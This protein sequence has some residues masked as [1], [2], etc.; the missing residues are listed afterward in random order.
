[1][2]T[3]VLMD[4]DEAKESGATALFGEKYDATVRV[5][6]VNDFS[7]ELC[8]GT[9][10]RATGEIGLCKIVSETGIAA[11]VR[12]VEAITG[13]LAL[14]KFQQAEAE[15]DGLA[16][17]L[18]TSSQELPA[19]VSKLLARQKE[20]EK[21]VS[22][23]TARLTITDLDR[24]ISE[25]KD[26]N[27]VRLV[28]AQIP[29]DSPKTLREVGD[30]IRDKMGTGVAV[31]GGVFQK[32]AALLAIVSKDMTSQYHAGKIIKEVASRVGGSGGGRP[33]MAQAGG[34]MT[35]KLPE[36]LAAAPAIIADM[37]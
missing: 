17:L 8:G 36:A 33:D 16:D 35:D 3:T 19:R 37:G 9:H 29:L 6:S 34:P 11:G 15:I 25:A 7:K 22:Q 31:I 14:E 12:R 4:K 5:V 2:V 32:K 10:V 1:G 18:K 13:G 23:L 30:R 24:L 27:G 20:L 28:T 26:V 21:E